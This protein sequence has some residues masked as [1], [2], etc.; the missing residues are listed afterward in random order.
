[1]APL[2]CTPQRFSSLVAEAALF[3]SDLDSGV[4]DVPVGP[5][6]RPA[7]SVSRLSDS[8]HASR[9]VRDLAAAAHARGHLQPGQHVLARR[10][11]HRAECLPDAGAYMHSSGRRRYGLRMLRALLCVFCLSSSVSDLCPFGLRRA[12]RGL[13]QCATV[14]PARLI[15]LLL[16]VCR[17]GLHHIVLL[18]MLFPCRCDSHVQLLNA[19]ARCL[20]LNFC[21]SAS[22]R[23][24]GRRVCIC[25]IRWRRTR[26]VLLCA[27]CCASPSRG[28]C[29]A[30]RMRSAPPS[31]SR[32]HHFVH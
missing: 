15:R 12:V 21:K 14:S 16:G 8:P 1:M 6:V 24:L 7:R 23:T 31:T 5:V 29:C 13:R 4:E 25:W 2:F 3:F 19:Q 30:M 18:M 10:P 11:A 28:G 22:S 27:I 9:F 17:Q 32:P 20:P 26:T